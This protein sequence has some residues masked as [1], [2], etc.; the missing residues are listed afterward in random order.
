MHWLNGRR[1]A[2]G[3]GGLSHERLLGIFDPCTHGIQFLARE[4]N[5]CVG[6]DV[7]FAAVHE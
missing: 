3:A 1:L 4:C 6:M 5:Q 2:T 7:R